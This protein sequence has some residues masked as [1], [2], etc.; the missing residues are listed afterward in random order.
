MTASC[1]ILA[2]PVC[3]ALALLPMGCHRPDSER[4]GDQVLDTASAFDVDRPLW[5]NR[6]R[7][8][9]GWIPTLGRDP[10]KTPAESVSVVQAGLD[11]AAKTQPY[12]QTL[13]LIRL[14]GEMGWTCRGCG[15]V[16]ND[17]MAL[18]AWDT[19]GAEG[20]IQARTPDGALVA[21]MTLD[22]TTRQS[23]Q[24][25]IDR[26]FQRRSDSSSKAFCDRIRQD[27]RNFVR[28]KYTGVPQPR[29]RSR[30]LREPDLIGQFSHFSSRVVDLELDDYLDRLDTISFDSVRY[31]EL[32]SKAELRRLLS[33]E[34]DVLGLAANIGVT[35]KS[36]YWRIS[37]GDI[38]FRTRR[39]G[40]WR[41]TSAWNPQGEPVAWNALDT[42]SGFPFPIW[43]HLDRDACLEKT[44]SVASRPSLFRRIFHLQ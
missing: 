27:G 6:L 32:A 11:G 29:N 21:W 33:E 1:S 26:G 30:M 4:V 19:L 43:F 23:F 41:V 40:S 20:V 36:C 5:T 22:T 3:I 12:W 10:A 28:Q 42:A 13:A 38:S 9:M 17:P 35:S 44:D 37:N 31:S 8:R 39:T 7:I 18:I 24:F 34:L 16:L 2:A 25:F 14:H 15:Y